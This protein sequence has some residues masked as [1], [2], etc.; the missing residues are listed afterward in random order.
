MKLSQFVCIWYNFKLNKKDSGTEKERCNFGL[1]GLIA[2]MKLETKLLVRQDSTNLSWQPSRNLVSTDL[3]SIKSLSA[4]IEKKRNVSTSVQFPESVSL[5]WQKLPFRRPQKAFFGNSQMFESL[6]CS[7]APFCQSH[8]FCSVCLIFD[9]TL[10][11]A[12]LPDPIT[13]SYSRVRSRVN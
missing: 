10:Q 13:L 7:C 12:D 1:K 8:P 6:K 3:P 5:E 4:K 2:A 9:F 11:S